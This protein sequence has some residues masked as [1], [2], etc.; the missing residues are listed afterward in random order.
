[1]IPSL[2]AFDGRQTFHPCP[3]LL[4]T[5]RQGLEAGLH[6]RVEVSI[7]TRFHGFF[8]AVGMMQKHGI[9]RDAWIQIT[10]AVARGALLSSRQE[11]R[12]ALDRQTGL[13]TPKIVEPDQSKGQGAIRVE[14]VLRGADC[15][16]S[17]SAFSQ[18]R[19]RITG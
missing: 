17:R 4:A 11:D 10:N 5:A 2:H 16:P 15:R 8:R 13:A 19:P 18:Q 1:M 6:A 12:E 3:E 14:G 7:V 9:R